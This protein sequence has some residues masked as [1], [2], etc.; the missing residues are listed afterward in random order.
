MIEVIYREEATNGYIK[1]DY[2]KII[3]YFE[4]IN[5]TENGGFSKGLI[6]VDKD[7]T[8]ALQQKIKDSKG[9]PLTPAQLEKQ[10]SR[11]FIN[12]SIDDVQKQIT[13]GKNPLEAV[14]R[15]VNLGDDR[16]TVNAIPNTGF[17]ELN[18]T[19]ENG[20]VIKTLIDPNTDVGRG[21]I[22]RAYGHELPG[23][24][25]DRII[26]E[27]PNTKLDDY[28]NKFE[29][30]KG[31]VEKQE[32]KE[33]V[34]ERI[35]KAMTPLKS[36]NPGEDTRKQL[37]D[38]KDEYAKINIGIRKPEDDDDD[39]MLIIEDVTGGTHTLDVT[40][41]K[42]KQKFEKI[43]RITKESVEAEKRD[44]ASK[45]YKRRLQSN[46][47]LGR[48]NKNLVEVNPEENKNASR[49]NK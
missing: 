16:I 32:A 14:K 20:T 36:V 42:F 4:D 37:L 48:P 21:L 1:E 30:R 38:A 24:L 9:K 43:L 17:I 29:K 12:R 23:E 13:D 8:K 39:T 2:K 11:D 26:E 18:R 28:K 44:N 19:N 15:L 40:D 3:N 10:R 31:L 45:E 47:L 22:L 5:M 6:E 7:A 46:E 25:Q 41:A 33:A 34:D 35:V 49:F 27:P